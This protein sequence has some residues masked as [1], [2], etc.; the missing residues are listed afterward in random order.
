MVTYPTDAA[1]PSG[2][3][4]SVATSCSH[5][6][7]RSDASLAELTS[8]LSELEAA[9]RAPATASPVINPP[10]HGCPKVV[11]HIWGFKWCPNTDS[12]AAFS[13]LER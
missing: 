5:E 9:S 12:I 10:D 1:L 6:P 2:D 11:G 13:G 4:S 7:S 3:E 8:M